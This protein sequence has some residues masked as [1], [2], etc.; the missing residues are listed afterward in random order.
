MNE[1]WPIMP[2][3]SLAA[4]TT[5]VLEKSVESLQLLIYGLAC[6]ISEVP[7][8]K[9]SRALFAYAA[10]QLSSALIVLENRRSTS[11]ATNEGNAREHSG[12]SCSAT[13]TAISYKKPLLGGAKQRRIRTW[14][15]IPS[16]STS[17]RQKQ[18]EESV[19]REQHRYNV[20]NLARRPIEP[21]LLASTPA[22][23]DTANAS[24][25]SD[26]KTAAALPLANA[27]AAG[28]AQLPRIGASEPPIAI[29]APVLGFSST[30]FEVEDAGT[31]TDDCDSTWEGT[32]C[33]YDGDDAHSTDSCSTDESS[34]MCT[35]IAPT[36]ESSTS[37]STIS[38]GECIER[39]VLHRSDPELSTR[40]VHQGDS[41]CTRMTTTRTNSTSTAISTDNAYGMFASSSGSCSDRHHNQLETPDPVSLFDYAVHQTDTMSDRRSNGIDIE[42][43][44]TTT[45]LPVEENGATIVAGDSSWFL[46]SRDTASSPTVT[47]GGLAAYAARLS[48]GT[49]SLTPPIRSSTAAR[50]ARSIT[51]CERIASEAARELRHFVEVTAPTLGLS[52]CAS[53]RAPHACVASGAQIPHGSNLC[54]APRYFV[55]PDASLH[56]EV[57]YVLRRALTATHIDQNSGTSSGTNTSSSTNSSARRST[58]CSSSIVLPAPP[59]Q[60]LKTPA[61]IELP[62]EVAEHVP[63]WSLSWSWSSSGKRAAA[64]CNGASLG[65]RRGSAAVSNGALFKW[66]STNHFKHGRNLTRKDLLQRNLSRYA[67]L[68]PAIAALFALQPPTFVLPGQYLEFA[69]AFGRAAATTT[70]GANGTSN[71]WILKPAHL[72]RGR[73]IILVECMQQVQ[74]YLGGGGQRGATADST[75][76]SV[77]SQFAST[78]PGHG[79]S[80]SAA[81]SGISHA[82]TST[83]S[84]SS[85][86][87]TLS[88]TPPMAVGVAAAAAAAVVQKYVSHPLLLDGHKFDLRLYVLVTSF[89]PLKAYV[90]TE[91]FARFALSP[92]GMDTRRRG[93]KLAHLTNASLQM[94]NGS[95]ACALKA[96]VPSLSAASDCDIGGSKCTLRLLFQVL[97]QVKDVDVN[98]LWTRI[99]G[100]IVRSLVCVQDVIPGQPGAFELYG[101]D[102][103][104]DAAVRPWLLEVNASPSLAVYGSRMDERVKTRVLA[105]LVAIVAPPHIHDPMELARDLESWAASGTRQS[106]AAPVS[107][108]LSRSSAGSSAAC[109]TSAM[110]DAAV[111]AELANGFECICPSTDAYVEAMAI[112]SSLLKR[113]ASRRTGAAT[114][115]AA[116]AE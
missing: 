96:A 22:H 99:V 50:A 18:A 102:I 46:H 90:H 104:V 82:A 91:G 29:V 65:S 68:G 76:S 11:S 5:V 110:D 83:T 10:K 70:E 95:G 7:N 100:L 15:A 28:T 3:A 87:S 107:L 6:D 27:H 9:E 26:S 16:V 75:A 35:N 41:I 38:E 48:E 47:H 53:C 40:T 103:L 111:G 112:K 2:L 31:A 62:P 63:I 34:S 58:T 72:S 43:N 73:G 17:S 108:R 115:A 51:L 93:D 86:A 92:Y 69:A 80:L 33:E 8:D 77:R 66:Q 81:T 44:E 36:R 24:A 74:Q 45:C 12:S 49:D 14:E 98:L 30:Q 113:Y 101:Y 84:S 116:N 109:S 37:R 19:K 71:M 54:E 13:H 88:S 57:A 21:I 79:Q 60:L 20:I 25:A 67:V 39:R 64:V 23:C 78:A 4:C 32:A 106:E 89:S 114:S 85:F 52:S 59:V 1:D 105:D 61:W 56:P 94:T 42:V 55:L 97:R